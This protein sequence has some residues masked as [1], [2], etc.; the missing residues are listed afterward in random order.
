VHT[1]E[2]PAPVKKERGNSYFAQ[3][4][5]VKIMKVNGMFLH[6]RVEARVAGFDLDEAILRL[7]MSYTF[8]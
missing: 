4:L 6:G 8:N 1:G 5:D 2:C 7:P 3:G